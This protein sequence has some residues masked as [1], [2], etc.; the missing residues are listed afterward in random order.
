MRPCSTCHILEVSNPSNFHNIICI[1]ELPIELILE[2]FYFLHPRELAYVARLST[3]Y[4]LLAQ[5]DQLWKPL[6]LRAGY[7]C[8]KGNPITTA[9]CSQRVRHPQ[10]WVEGSLQI[11]QR[12]RKKASHHH[13][14]FNDTQPLT[15]QKRPCCE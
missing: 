9:L 7:D 4:F 15:A 1:P 14:T 11:V 8:V 12:L 3:Q 5:D 10:E 6:C 13:N 2:I